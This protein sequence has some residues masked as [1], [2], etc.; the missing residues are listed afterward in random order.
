[1]IQLFGANDDTTLSYFSKRLGDA[2]TVSRSS[3]LPSREQRI[4]D[5][6]TGASWSVSTNPL[7]TP[8]EIE[9]FFA[10]DDPK[11]RQLV[12]RP[13]YRPMILQRAFYDKSSFFAGKFDEREN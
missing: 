1:M 8:S 6:A 5:A 3:N 2:M 13:G 9:M 4:R 7:M 11:L 10:R 12:L